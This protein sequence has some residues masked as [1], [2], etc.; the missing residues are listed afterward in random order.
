MDKINY[1]TR[2]FSRAEK[3]RFEHYVVTRIWHLL[4]DLTIKFITQQYVVRPK[5]RALTDMFF[6]Q[7]GIHIEVDETHH[8][9]QQ[10]QDKLRESDIVNATNH[11]IEK[12]DT[13]KGIELL[14]YEIDKVVEKIRLEKE[15]TIDFKPWDIAAEQNP[16]R[17]IDKGYIKIS[18]DVAFNHSYLAAN[19][20]GHNYQGFQKGGTLHPKDKNILIWFP[21]LYKKRGWNNSISDDENTI[22]EISENL[23]II[24]PHIDTIKNGTVHTRI[25]FARVRSPLG[26]IM[27]RFKGEFKL[28]V[29]ETNYTK[30]LIWKKVADE[31]TTYGYNCN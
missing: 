23:N 5:G 26:D 10:E 27:Y 4:N 3:K 9:N 22:T 12:I 21:K 24:N 1:V 29:E 15:S 30:G 14:N 19:C 2:Q 8:L 20:F 16:K 25:V 13:S 17:Y 6:P 7:L 28:D 31:V 11:K 18:D